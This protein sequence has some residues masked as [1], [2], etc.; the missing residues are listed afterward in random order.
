MVVISVSLCLVAACPP[1]LPVPAVQDLEVS[2]L[3][4]SSSSPVL[5]GTPGTPHL[6]AWPR[7]PA[8]QSR[9]DACRLQAGGQTTP[10]PR[11]VLSSLALHSPQAVRAEPSEE[12]GALRATA[13]AGGAASLSLLL[14]LPAL[15]A[16][17]AEPD[18][19]QLLPVQETRKIPPPPAPPQPPSWPPNVLRDPHPPRMGLAA[20][21]SDSRCSGCGGRDSRSVGC[22]LFGPRLA[23]CGAAPSPAPHSCSSRCC[24]PAG[25]HV[26]P[27]LC[28]LLPSPAWRGA[29]GIRGPC[30]PPLSPYSCP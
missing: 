28:H 27:T 26:H 24:R 11:P 15:L 17:R 2:G 3:L 6:L 10:L 21:G 9:A 29:P 20:S 18:L 12:T 13:L 4:F 25:P 16:V 8:P 5:S 1:S 19:T 23:G 22:S 7:P 14:G 30:L